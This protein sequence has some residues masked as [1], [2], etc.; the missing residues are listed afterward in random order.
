MDQEVSD[1][2]LVVWPRPLP[3]PPLQM[4]LPP[5]LV[6]P[7]LPRQTDHRLQQRQQQRVWLWWEGPIVRWEG[8]ILRPGPGLG[9]E[10][11]AEGVVAVLPGLLQ[12]LHL[13]ET[14]GQPH[15]GEEPMRG[16]W[17]RGLG[18]VVM[19]TGPP[20]LVLQPLGIEQRTQSFLEASG[21]EGERCRREQSEHEDEEPGGEKKDKM[22]KN[23]R[24]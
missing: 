22:E 23:R 4:L 14:A 16:D 11:Q 15:Q 21:P 17:G 9:G 10:Q 7:R 12:L 13:L 20:Q 5:L 1:R 6:S 18:L 2:H 24:T 3:L 8:L 19:E